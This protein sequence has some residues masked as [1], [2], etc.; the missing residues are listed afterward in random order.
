VVRFADRN[1]PQSARFDGLGQT[2]VVL[3]LALLDFSVPE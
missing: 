2:S 1:R 3:H